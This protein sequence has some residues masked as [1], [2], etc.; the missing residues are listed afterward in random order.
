MERTHDRIH[1]IDNPALYRLESSSSSVYYIDT[2]THP[3]VMRA[4]GTGATGVGPFDD[5]WV[6]LRLLTAFAPPEPGADRAE[7][8]FAV[9]RLAPWVI[10]VGHRHDMD[11]RVGG[12]GYWMIGREVTRIV[13][14]DEMPPEGERT[15]EESE[16]LEGEPY[17]FRRDPGH[18][19]R[20]LW[21]DQ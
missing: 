20:G 19:N 15:I 3:R 18:E 21:R 10:A 5:T 2:R 7:E 13:E 4:R 8:N 1:V 12:S 17:D 6:E 14:L 16:R 9:Q 11:Y